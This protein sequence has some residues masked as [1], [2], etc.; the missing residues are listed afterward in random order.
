MFDYLYY[1]FYRAVQTGS[2]KDLSQY[3]TPIY[4]GGIIGVNILVI[5][6]FFVKIGALPYI[7]ANTKQGGLVILF[8]IILATIYYKKRRKTILEKYSNES[9]TERKKGNTIATI[10]VALSLISM[11]AIAFFRKGKL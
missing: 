1:K 3:V 2:L 9:I 11:F 6:L 5:Y 8:F 7:F 4:L 10:Y